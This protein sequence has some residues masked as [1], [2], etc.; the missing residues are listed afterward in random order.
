MQKYL[1]QYIKPLI[2]SYPEIGTVLNAHNIG[3]TDCSV[4]TCKLID[5]IEIHNLDSEK[6]L[7]VINDLGKIIYGEAPYTVPTIEKKQ[8]S[9]KTS[10][11]PAI[12]K[13][14]NEHVYIKKVI[15]AVP[16]LLE[17]IDGSFDTLKPV[18][19][20][21]IDFIKNYADGYHHAKEEDILFGF[22]DKDLD[23]LAVMY[24]DHDTGR[25]FVKNTLKGI[26]EKNTAAIKENML[27]YCELLTQHIKKEDEILFPWMDRSLN[28]RQIG[29]LYSLCS[30]VDTKFG[31]KPLEYEAFAL[32]LEEQHLK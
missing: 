30:A 5:I 29:E 1:D 10:Y 25:N 19:E 12:R 4:G 9:D 23:I 17:T 27:G 15:A 22:F 6:T 13:L 21:C 16:V 32:S 7:E 26:E 8:V 14:M 2:D 28:D 24:E 18:L 11:S 20:Q 3:C 31:D